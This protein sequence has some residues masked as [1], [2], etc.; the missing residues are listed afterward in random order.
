[1]G[2][3]ELK[4]AI[5]NLAKRKSSALIA[6][7]KCDAFVSS[8]T[9]EAA[10]GE[11]LAL[12]GHM[13]GA[14]DLIPVEFE[15][16]DRDSGVSVQDRRVQPYIRSQLFITLIS[17]LE[18]FLARAI[19]NVLRVYPKKIGTHQIALSQLVELGYEG[20][21][22]EAIETKLRQLFYASPREYKKALVEY[23]SLDE[24]QLEMWP[25]FVEMKARRDV[26]VHGEWIRNEVYDRKVRDSGGAV[27]SEQ[28]LGIGNEYFDRS[29]LIGELLIET[30]AIHVMKKFAVK[31]TS[32]D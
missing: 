13:R 24:G 29:I 5:E 28:F 11:G 6:I 32:E 16:L 19:R 1:M 31:G 8:A 18:D 20:A 22:E 17:E 30:L 3:D 7:R 12:F 9:S 14:A 2:K 25:C 15:S 21:I 26:G 10:Y 27:T 23:L 4:I